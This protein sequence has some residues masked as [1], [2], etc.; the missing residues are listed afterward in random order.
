MEF[1]EALDALKDGYRVSRE[2]WNG[3]GMYVA[4]M[5]PGCKSV[6]QQPYLYMCPVGGKFIPW[7][8]S[9]AD[10][11]AEDWTFPPTPGD[12]VGK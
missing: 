10:L 1:G 12:I 6:M 5:V 7:L 3:K 2:G 11:L 8:A 9:Q 4:L